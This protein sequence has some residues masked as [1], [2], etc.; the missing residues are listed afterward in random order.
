M[1]IRIF[2]HYVDVPMWLLALVEGLVLVG[3]VYL[4]VHLRFIS[5][6]PVEIAKLGHL[7]L[8]SIVIST[9]M[10]LILVAL[11]MYN[12]ESNWGQWGHFSIYLA[13]FF[14]GFIVLTVVFYVVPALYLG[15]GVLALSLALGFVGITGVRQLYFGLID[16]EAKAKRVLVLGGGSRS[17]EIV[18]LL[19][20]GHSHRFSLAGFVSE[21][22]S[23][24][25]EKIQSRAL[26]VESAVP[27]LAHA[28][29]NN[30]NEIVVGVRQRRDG[31]LNMKELLECRLEGLSV[32]DLP[33]FFERETG[34]VMLDSLNP[35]WVVFSQ[36]FNRG[37]LTNVVKRAIDIVMSVVLLVLFL[38]VMALTAVLIKLDSR[39]PVLYR[40]QRVGECGQVFDVLKFRS[41][42]VDAEKNGQPQWAQKQ[43]NRVTR[44]GGIIRKLRI[45]ELPQIF[46][47][48]KGD[49]SFVGPRPERPFFVKQLVEHIPYYSARHSVKPGITGWAQVRYPYG[50]SI[51]DAKEKL[52]YDLYYAKN[53]SWFL[54]LIIIFETV[55][56][57]LFGK[58]AR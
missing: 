51:E 50:S 48:L 6:S 14:I 18:T 52:Q 27:L 49:M 45:D 46:N 8:K 47:V 1:K 58:G 39:G 38:P 43:D 4:A 34:K 23:V 32:V 12:I 57:V 3:A 15:R 41:M 36:G 21:S 17:A 30:V 24:L 13:S 16:R 55:Q 29:R 31:A 37:T 10:L 2:G 42:T 11:G 33:T 54:D 25:D 53:H 22:L 35:S 7:P 44:I 9:V 56:V 19:E 40:Q 26:A 5:E 20:K 28:R